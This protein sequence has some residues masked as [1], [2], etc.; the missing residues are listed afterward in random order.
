M[1]MN[2]PVDISHFRNLYP[3]KS[4]YMNLNG[5][6]YHFLDEGAG[7]PVVMIHGN[8]TWSFYYRNLINKLSPHFRAIAV[9]HIGCGLSDKPGI[10]RYNYTLKNRVDDIE[11]FIDFLEL[12][13]KITLILHDWGGMIGIAYALR[14]PQRIS[15]IIIMNTAA[16]F[17]PGKK[18]LPLRLRLVRNV[19]LLATPAVLGLN[20]F[21]YSALYMATCKGLSKEVK[22]GLTA[23]Y[24]CWKNRLATL[25]FVQDIPV[26]K[27]DT[28]YSLVKSTDENLDKL[29]G[30]PMLICWG[31]QDFVFDASYLAEWQ[32]RFPDAEVHTFSNAGH[33]VLEDEPEKV[34]TLVKYFLNRHSV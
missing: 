29:A 28:S 9:D 8:P 2:K 32:R 17:P 19:R 6:K 27:K 33:Y 21:A 3:F 10:D 7:E 34:C 1:K 25:K 12:Q 14:F 24:N 5:L 4:C 11:A 16:F 20:L 18:K 22:S 13:D 26:S 23:P 31:K 30:I 15:R